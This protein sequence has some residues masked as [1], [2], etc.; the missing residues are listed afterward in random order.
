MEEGQVFHLYACSLS[1][2]GAKHSY[3]YC[4]RYQ[5]MFERSC[6]EETAKDLPFTKDS[7]SILAGKFRT[8]PFYL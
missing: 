7:T 8:Y 5:Q 6:I 2:I 3:D 4:L 1:I